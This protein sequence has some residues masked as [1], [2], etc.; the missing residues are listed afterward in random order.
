MKCDEAA[1]LVQALVDSELDAGHAHEV[2]AHARSCARCGAELA[3]AQ[4]M[5][6]AL[7]GHR[8]SFA[9]PAGLRAKIERQA[10]LLRQA[11]SRRAVLKGFV[12]GS[13]ASALAAATVGLVVLR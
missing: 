4:E 2:E 7:A 1:L 11:Q 12:A 3:A 10:P 6:R 5:R 9:A 13:A 8:L